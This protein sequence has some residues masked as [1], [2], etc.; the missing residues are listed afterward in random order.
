[1]IYDSGE[2]M[3]VFLYGEGSTGKAKLMEVFEKALGNRLG[4]PKSGFLTGEDKFRPLLHARH[5]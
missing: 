4:V 2:A 3:A 5:L 1:M